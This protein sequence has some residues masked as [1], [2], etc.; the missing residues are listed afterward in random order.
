MLGCV[1]GSTKNVLL[2]TKS[3]F[4][5]FI[6]VIVSLGLAFLGW[7][8]NPFGMKL[9]WYFIPL[10]L[11]LIIAFF[12]AHIIS[13]VLGTLVYGLFLGTSVEWYATKSVEFISYLFGVYL[14]LWGFDTVISAVINAF[15][16][17]KLGKRKKN[18]DNSSPV[19]YI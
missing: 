2:S 9:P 5:I 12:I 7:T 4:Y 18:D 3:M 17:S 13:W 16:G 14:T 8:T 19:D 6:A 15:F 1:M 11:F 10:R